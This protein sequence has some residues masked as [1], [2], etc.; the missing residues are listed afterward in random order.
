MNKK[1]CCRCL[2]FKE[3]TSNFFGKS[4]ISKDGFKPYCKECKKEENRRY[5]KSK[6][7][8]RQKKKIEKKEINL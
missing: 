7:S 5:K 2:K 4:N 6:D 8:Y 3:L 1:Q